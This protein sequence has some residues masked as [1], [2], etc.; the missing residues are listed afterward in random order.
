M[1]IAA[2]LYHDEISHV[3][4]YAVYMDARIGGNG[5][6]DGIPEVVSG[7]VGQNPVYDRITWD[8]D[9]DDGFDTGTVLGSVAATETG[10]GPHA[11]TPRGGDVQAFSSTVSGQIDKVQIRALAQAAGG[12]EWSNVAIKFYNH[13]V[14]VDSYAADAG[15]S[16]DQSDATGWCESEA[17]LEVRPT[18]GLVYDQVVV[19]GSFRLFYDAER[20]E[21][22]ATDLAGQIFI[23]TANT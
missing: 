23:Y 15:P 2:T 8:S 21:P 13:G 7:R 12:V 17:I 5:D 14:L 6:P 10:G 11:S 3:S 20:V 19:D 4:G 22:G 9:L 16:V 18:A 1:S